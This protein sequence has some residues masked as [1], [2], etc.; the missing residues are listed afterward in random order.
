MPTTDKTLLSKIPLDINQRKKALLDYAIYTVLVELISLRPVDARN[1]RLAKHP[2][3]DP[4]RSATS[5]F[6]AD[7]ISCSQKFDALNTMK[8]KSL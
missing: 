3:Y 8:D 1:L 7:V 4:R 6:E 2:L 5:E